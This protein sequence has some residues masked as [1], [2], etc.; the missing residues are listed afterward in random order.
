[1]N[2]KIICAPHDAGEDDPLPWE[3]DAPSGGEIRVVTADLQHHG[4]R[5]DKGLAAWIPELSRS[6]LAQL[7][8]EG[9]VRINGK[10]AL[11][12]AIKLSTGQSIEIE[13]RPTPA[14][15][16]F[17]AEP[18]PLKIVFEDEHLLVI[19]KPVGLV[20]HP[21]SGNWT[22]TLLNGLLHH[23]AEAHNLPRAGIVHRLDKNTSG[24]MVVAKSRQAMA[25]LVDQLATRSVQRVYVALARGRKAVGDVFEIDQ[26]I[27]RDPKNRL[28][29]AVVSA[30]KPAQTE[31]TVRSAHAPYLMLRC[32]LR[33]GRTHQIRVHMA[34]CG[35]PLVGDRLYGG[36]AELGMEAQALHAHDLSLVH[37]VTGATLHWWVPPPPEWLNAAE[38]GGLGYNAASLL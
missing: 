38:L 35:M 34:W 6:Y 22:G 33:T 1:M 27:G 19:N 3:A 17:R 4:T 5:L 14:A 32:K 30:G 12:P 20:V 9:C 10:L 16:A 21:G 28:R 24:L 15:S 37:P 25:H 7:I 13:L 31:V 8:E 36:A 18:V 29:M 26:P 23:H 11:K 2:Q